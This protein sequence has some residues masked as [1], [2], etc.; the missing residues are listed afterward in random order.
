MTPDRNVTQLHSRV[1]LDR[2]QLLYEVT[3]PKTLLGVNPPHPGKQTVMNR[4]ELA[5]AP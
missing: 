3:L 2:R 1:Y 5:Y 4:R